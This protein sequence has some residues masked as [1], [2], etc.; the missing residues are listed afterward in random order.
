MPNLRI[1]YDNAADRAKAITATT[2]SGGLVATNLLNDTKSLT[3]RSTGTSVSY[4][5]TWD[6][7]QII[8]AVVLPCSN[9]SQTATIRVRL[10][11]DEAGT[12]LIRDSGTVAASNAGNVTSQFGLLNVNTFA[13]GGFTKT[14]VW[15]TKTSNVRRC[16][17]D[18]V[19]TANPAGFIECSRLVIGNYWSPKYNFEPGVTY[20]TVDT[21]EIKRAENG[22]LRVDQ[23]FIYEKLAFNFSLLPESDLVELNK[24]IKQVGITKNILVS[25]VPEYDTKSIEDVYLIYGKRSNSQV[26][27]STY[28]Y[29]VSSL[30]IQ[31][32]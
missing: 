3:H 13:F 8:S 10:F 15:L 19:D 5:V 20:E 22:D 14:S 11:S 6:T 30:E 25:L 24:I 7:G 9:L 2:T 27:Y 21:S 12:T 29:Y 18:L 28:K 1:I 23:K 31:S 26:R 4:V 32:W 17:I 16:T